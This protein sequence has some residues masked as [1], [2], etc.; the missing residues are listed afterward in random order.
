MK[1]FIILGLLYIFTAVTA[2]GEEKQTQY[3]FPEFE[4]G[5]VLYRNGSVYN[6]QLNFSLVSNRFVFIDTSDKNTIKEFGQPDMIGS[7]KT[8]GR[9]FQINSKGEA[10]EILQM[11]NPVISVEYKG[12]IVD[13]GRK[14]AYGGRSQTSSIDSYTSI[15]SGGLSYKLE[16]DDRWIINGIEKKYQVEY[17]GKRNSFSTAKQFLKIY[18]KRQAT[19]IQEFIKNKNINFNSVEQVT[20]L[21][22]YADSLN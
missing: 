5:Q 3:L 9:V 1:R 13:R 2:R 22:N 14:S 11:E 17:K 15:Q 19:V 10:N 20:D 16:G 8:G 18:P 12:K 4:N 21:C 6:V 7:V